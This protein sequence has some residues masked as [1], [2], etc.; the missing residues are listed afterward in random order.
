MACDGSLRVSDVEGPQKYFV[1]EDRAAELEVA[2]FRR[3]AAV[4]LSLGRDRAPAVKELY[5]DGRPWR[6]ATPGRGEPER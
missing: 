1:P 5:L 2:L 3:E 6:E 4:L